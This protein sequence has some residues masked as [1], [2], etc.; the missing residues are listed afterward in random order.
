MCQL[1]QVMKRRIV[2]FALCV[3]PIVLGFFIRH[4]YVNSLPYAIQ[5]FSVALCDNNERDLKRWSTAHAREILQTQP[6]YYRAGMASPR[7]T[8]SMWAD[9]YLRRPVPVIGNG[10]TR[11]INN[12]K[13]SK[14]YAGG[15]EL[16]FAQINSGWKLVLIDSPNKRASER[17]MWQASEKE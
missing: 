15:Q 4:R 10:F 17:L 9:G 6:W 7:S 8:W 13:F 12:R 16:I 14:L 1:S 5:L 2:I 11:S 3:L